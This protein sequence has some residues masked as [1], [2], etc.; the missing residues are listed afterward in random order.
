MYL[1]HANYRNKTS[2]INCQNHQ[3][4]REHIPSMMAEYPVINHHN[5]STLLSPESKTV[6]VT[7]KQLHSWSTGRF[8]TFDRPLLRIWDHCSG[9]QPDEIGCMM[10]RA[11]LQRLDTIESRKTSLTTHLNHKEWTPTPYISFTISPAAN[12]ELA[13]FRS[14]RKY[15][16]VQTLTVIDPNTRLRDHLPVL[17]V[18]AEMDHYEIPNP[19]GKSNQ[20]YVD[21]YVC[22]WQVTEREIVG[23]WLWDD[24]ITNEDWNEQII[25]PAFRQFRVERLPNSCGDMAFDLSTAVNQLSRKSLVKNSITKLM[26]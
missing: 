16:G 21:H 6:L 20:Y 23:H 18:A 26:K 8:Q 9:S 10:S 1:Q 4:E 25:M 5:V 11:P 2:T 14:Q 19:Y 15:R 13:T 22:L 17:D 12:Q 24:L 7:E 3:P